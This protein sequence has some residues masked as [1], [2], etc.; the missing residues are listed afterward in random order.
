MPT[1]LLLA[2]TLA[3]SPFVHPIAAGWVSPPADLAVA[4]LAGLTAGQVGPEDVALVPSGEVPYLQE[5]HKVAPDA[6]IVFEEV[7]TVAMRCPVR[8][9]EIEATPVRLLETSSL[10]RLLARATVQPFYGI[11]PARWTDQDD[12]KAQV[13]IVEGSVALLPPEAGFSEDLSRAWFILT[14]EPVVAYVCLVPKTLDREALA[15]ALAALKEA[16]AI[17]YERRRELRRAVAEAQELPV[18]LVTALFGRLRLA[19]DAPDRRALLMLLQRGHPGGTAPFVR[20]LEFLDADQ[21]D[22]P[23]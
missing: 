1:R 20:N 4:R 17:G 16:G 9:D 11:P 7:G 13:V 6:A 5:T 10:A 2:D 14:G 8:P 15:P 12:A 3:T 23:D 22:A 18:E 19:L 21:R